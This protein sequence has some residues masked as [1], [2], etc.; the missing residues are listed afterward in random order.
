MGAVFPCKTLPYSI[1][2]AMNPRLAVAILAGQGMGD[3]RNWT[4]I[5][6]PYNPIFSPLD[7]IKP[8]SAKKALGEV[9]GGERKAKCLRMAIGCHRMQS[10]MGL[11]WTCQWG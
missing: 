2:G 7:L 5:P 11:I 10:L 4:L 9:L 6:P 8:M 3:P 1:I